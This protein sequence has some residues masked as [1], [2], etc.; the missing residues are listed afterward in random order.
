MRNE[1]GNK[2]S[3]Q[4]AGKGEPLSFALIALSPKN[5]SVITHILHHS[6][7]QASCLFHKNLI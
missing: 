7:E 5:E 3:Q 1:K 2:N 4:E 6:Q